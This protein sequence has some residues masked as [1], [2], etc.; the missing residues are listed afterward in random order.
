MDEVLLSEEVI[1]S[2]NLKG[3]PAW[4][5]RAL[6]IAIPVLGIVF[7]LDVPQRLGWLIFPEQYLGL[8]L[9]LTLCATFLIV[10]EGAWG[11]REEIPWYDVLAALAG[12]VIGLYVFVQYPR[13]A[14]SLGEIHLDRVIMGCVA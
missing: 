11:H 2:R 9:A 14:N 13:F 6:L 12:L 7:L 3:F 10:P 4:V 5:T 1:R 8:F